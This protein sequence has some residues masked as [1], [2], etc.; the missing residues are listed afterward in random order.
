MAAVAPIERSALSCVPSPLVTILDVVIAESTALLS[1]TWTVVVPAKPPPVS[2][3]VTVAPR[4]PAAGVTA[5]MTGARA[6]LTIDATFRFTVVG[7]AGKPKLTRAAA[8]KIGCGGW[9]V[10]AAD[11]VRL[12]SSLWMA[13]TVTVG[14]TGTAAGAVYSPS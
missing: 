3:T 10:T 14:D 1:S 7:V 2:V 8:T 5:V 13:V 6:M 4:A 9:I 11:A 12:W